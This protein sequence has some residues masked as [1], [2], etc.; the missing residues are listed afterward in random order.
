MQP[1]SRDAGY[2][3]DMLQHARGVSGSVTDK[4]FEEYL[5]DE[6]IRLS[7]ERRIEI[8]GEAAGHV[9]QTFKEAHPEIPWRKII[10]QRN[11]IAHEYG[12]IDDEIMWKVATVSIPELI[13]LIEPLIPNPPP[14][15][16]K[17]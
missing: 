3:L 16:E 8:I 10:S 7:V 14:D 9:S 2:L 6:V 11:I 17:K 12:E 13:S 5:A 4:S 15:I 1:D